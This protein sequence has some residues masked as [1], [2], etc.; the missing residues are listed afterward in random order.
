MGGG[1]GCGGRVLWHGE[2]VERGGGN[3]VPRE[4]GILFIVIWFVMMC[5]RGGF[6]CDEWA[7][8]LGASNLLIVRFQAVLERQQI[9]KNSFLITGAVSQRAGFCV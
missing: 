6:R 9:S 4:G 5:I 3:R 7:G 1:G 2:V 8:V